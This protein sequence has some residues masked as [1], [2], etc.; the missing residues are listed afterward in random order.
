LLLLWLLQNHPIQVKVAEWLRNSELQNLVLDE[1]NA[2]FSIRDTVLTFSDFSMTSSNIGVNLEGTQHLVTDRI[3][4]KATLLLPEQFKRGIATV[5]SNRA[6]D[7]LQRED[8]R[9]A[10]PILITGTSQNPRVG[11]DNE[12]IEEIIRDFLRDEA[13]GAIRRLFGN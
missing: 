7:A 3:N 6:A 9:M 4:Y 11:P 10:V 2:T 8:G 13:G 1:W 5:I 12:I